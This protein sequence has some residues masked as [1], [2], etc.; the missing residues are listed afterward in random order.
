M[1]S[2]FPLPVRGERPEGR[3]EGR[4]H[5]ARAGRHRRRGLGVAGASLATVCSVILAESVHAVDLKVDAIT[6]VQSVQLGSTTLVGGR[7]TMVRAR[8]GV[9]GSAT[10]VPGVDARLRVFVDNVELPSSP[11]YS[12][13]G[14]ITAPLSPSLTNIDH[15]VNF[16]VVLPEAAKV[17]FHVQVDPADMIQETDETNNS[18]SLLNQVLVCR[19]IVE[20]VSVP[21]NYTPGGGLPSAALIEPG[22]GDGFVRAIYAPREFNYHRTPLGPLTWTQGINGSS[23]A[24]LNTL[25]DQLVAQ[26]PAAGYPKPDFIYGWLPGNPYS[27][28]GQAIG[29][30]GD[31][32]FGNTD[33]IRFQRT[34]A[35][36]LGHLVGLT[37]NSATVGTT[38][39][40]VEHHLWNTESL[41]QTFPSNKFDVM[42]AGKLTKDAFVNQASFNMFLNSSK[43]ACPPTAAPPEGEGGEDDAVAGP[44]LRISGEMLHGPGTA[45]L[46]PIVRIDSHPL[47]QDDPTGD[48]RIVVRDAAGAPTW[49]IRVDTQRTREPCGHNPE[50]P[51]AIDASP[52]HVLVPAGVGDREPVTIEVVREA[53]GEVLASRNRSP[54]MPSVQIVEVAVTDPAIN[55]VPAPGAAA[56]PKPGPVAPLSGTVRVQWTALDLDGDALTHFLFYS[57]DDGQ[58]WLPL[59]VR[60]GEEAFEFDSA[61]IPSSLGLNSKF[62]VRTSDG[63]SSSDSPIYEAA[64][65]GM[66]NPPDVH[67]VSP[68]DGSTHRQHG[69]IVFTASGWDLEDRLLP[70]SSMVWTS[71][72]DGSFGAGRVLTASSLSPGV[73]TITVT[74]TDSTGM[75][76]S[77][78]IVLTIQPRAAMGPDLNLDDEIDGADLGLLLASWGTDLADLNGDGTVD[79]SDLGILLSRWTAR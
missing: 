65:M 63:F 33:P 48:L 14:P 54:S 64:A 53:T 17:D 31:A 25:K 16:V 74:G 52:F 19:D 34:F 71:S 58:S 5:R 6:V 38:G 28:N 77:R 13:N 67:L 50:A 23:N 41:D 47:T 1:P 18:L 66:G 70:H 43:V 56:P 21:V 59:G 7:S 72:L 27:G 22:V 44:T 73:H 29:I 24:L 11:I 51:P 61:A 42:V 2:C 40:D 46:D 9:V 35:H 76:S 20:I 57:P 32:A 4:L 30:P 79:G 75:S 36:E 55:A 37:H 45:L 69:Q 10:A 15:T 3:A 39:V 49:Q 8:I 26:I 62:F 78:S 12:C 60:L 68:N